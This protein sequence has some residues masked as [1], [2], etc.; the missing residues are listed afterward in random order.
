MSEPALNNDQPE[1]PGVADAL[2][3]EP[4]VNEA[5]NPAPEPGA[6]AEPAES[7]GLEPAAPGLDPAFA[8]AMSESMRAQGLSPAQGRALAEAYQSHYEAVRQA[9]VESHQREVIEAERSL[10][11]AEKEH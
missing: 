4:P 10:S 7:W 9:A 8:S 2:V 11:A 3:G 1:T 6:P 5:P